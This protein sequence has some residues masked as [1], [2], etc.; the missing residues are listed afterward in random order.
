MRVYLCCC[1][2][3]RL[4]LIHLTQVA[5]ISTAA[6]QNEGDFPSF[7]NLLILPKA[8]QRAH[9]ICMR[10]ARQH[11]ATLFFFKFYWY[12]FIYTQPGTRNTF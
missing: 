10:G 2:K 5:E 8:S 11:M 7:S 4:F 9:H 6:L 12:L 3:T 1:L